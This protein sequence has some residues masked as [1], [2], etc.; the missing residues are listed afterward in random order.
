MSSKMYLNRSL[1]V[2]ALSAGLAVV[3]GCERPPVDTEQKGYRGTG[4]EEVNNPRLR[5]D[6]LHL[7]PAAADPVSAEGPRAGEIYQNVEVLTDLSVAEFTRL[8]Q[9]MTDWVAP[10]EGCTYCH[11]GNDFASEELYTYQVSRQMIEMNRYVNAN[12]DSHMDDTGVTC[13]TCH[14]GENLPAES[15]FAEPTPDVNM[16]GLGNTMMQNLAS[17]KTEYTSLPRNAFERYLL[18]HDDLRVEGDTILP[19]L[20]EWDVSLQDT[21]AS[22]SLMMH[23]SAATGSNCTTCHNTGRL[24]Q[25]DES[26]EEREISWHGIRMAR[27]INANWIEPLEA[28]QP[29]VRLGPTGDI[30]KVQ[31]AT[32]HYGEQL[33]LDGAKMVDDYPGLMGEEDADF[34]FLQ[35][36]DLGTDGLRDR[37]AE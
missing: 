27:D 4:M 13:Y 10:D 5:D 24:G 22:Y 28:G 33:P 34:D 26:P 20:D 29:E 3:V 9:S 31:C 37:N 11:D 12:W 1:A 15:W 35:F 7:A 19:H 36:G 32:C 17:E 18:G 21:E 16:A 8:M 23:M 2:G 25:W 6:D 14:R 30:A